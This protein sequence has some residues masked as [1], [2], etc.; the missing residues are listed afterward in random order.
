MASG[1]LRS[2]LG[3]T[4]PRRLEPLRV[5]D[6]QQIMIGVPSPSGYLLAFPGPFTLSKKKNSMLP[7]PC[8]F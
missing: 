7:I 2:L 5:E 8:W 4:D 3:P 1:K 6:G